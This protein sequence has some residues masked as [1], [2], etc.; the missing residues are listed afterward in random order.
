MYAYR[1]R[2]ISCLSLI[3][4]AQSGTVYAHLHIKIIKP[5]P[6]MLDCS[7]QRATYGLIHILIYCSVII[8]GTSLSTGKSLCT[9]CWYADKILQKR[10][11]LLPSPSNS[12]C[13]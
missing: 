6:K 2:T 1:Y 7:K 13:W 9:I 10:H 4:F 3:S 11:S 5:L 8:P 12:S